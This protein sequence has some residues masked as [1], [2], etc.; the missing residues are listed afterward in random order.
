V[1][2]VAQAKIDGLRDHYG[3]TEGP[4]LSFFQVHATLDVEHS[5]AER[6]MIE[7][8]ANG[9]ADRV[10]DATSLAL[11]GWWGFLDAVDPAA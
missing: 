3:I 6:T 1:P 2:E 9:D 11:E 4:A 5:D 7:S 10:V 8:L